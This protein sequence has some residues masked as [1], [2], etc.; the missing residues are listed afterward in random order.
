MATKTIRTTST[1]NQH[2]HTYDDEMSG[3]TSEENGHTHQ[4]SVSEDGKVNIS[5][6]D[7]HT[8]QPATENRNL[9]NQYD[10]KSLTYK[11]VAFE[12]KQT[13]EDPEFFFF[14]GYAS[15]F[16]NIDRGSDIIH[17][18]AFTESLTELKPKVLWGHDMGSPPIGV[19]IEA[20]EDARGLF[21]KARLPKADTFVSGRIMPQVKNGSIDSMSIGFNIID[22]D[23]EKQDD[24]FIRNI[25]KVKLWEYSLVTI[26]MNAEAM[27]TGH[28]SIVEFQDL[29]IATDDKGNANMELEWN[30][31]EAIERVKELVGKERDNLKQAYLISN[32]DKSECDPKYKMPIADVIDGELKVVPKALYSAASALRGLK[33]SIDIDDS[34]KKTITQNINQYFKKAG[35]QSPL[36]KSLVD[37]IDSM[38]NIKE[39]SDLLKGFLSRRESD[40]LIKAVKRIRSEKS[41]KAEKALV[42]EL[43]DLCDIMKRKST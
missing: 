27:L 16:G 34:A 17:R 8:H 35:L 7:G 3:A 5:E 43:N 15:T 20:F 30:A 19:S 26:P 23:M 12:I 18:G 38:K 6:A 22:F 25:R 32:I 10:A 28:K 33:H 41:V 1:V 13:E 9:N 37:H 2:T 4:Y 14:E 39:V 21:V 40:A 31:T 24:N 42:Q 11:K 29:P 36:E